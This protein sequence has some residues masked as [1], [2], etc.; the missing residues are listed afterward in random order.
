MRKKGFFITFEGTDGVGKSTHLKLAADW[1]SKQGASLLTTR[2]PGGGAVSERIRHLLLDPALEMKGLT[3]LF[4]YQAARVEHVQNIL[5]P[6]LAEGK[7]V[8]CDRFTDATLA[9]QGHARQ[10]QKPAVLLNKLATGGLVPDLTILL[11]LPPLQGLER[12]KQAKSHT[13]RLENEGLAFQK[14]VH[15]GYLK[16][17]KNNSKRIKVVNVRASMEDTQNVIRDIITRSLRGHSWTTPSAPLLVGR[18]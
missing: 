11:N 18:N 17:A 13:D 16:L 14:A 2:E 12:A 1:L 7:I 10:L 3:E 5:N 8:L 9:Y 15:K 4:L 6:A